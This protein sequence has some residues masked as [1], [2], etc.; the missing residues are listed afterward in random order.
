MNVVKRDGSLE[1]VN[2]EKV[3]KRI[4]L[5]ATEPDLLPEPNAQGVNGSEKAKLSKSDTLEVNATLIAQRTLMRIRDGIKTSELDELAAQLSISLVT[6]HPDYG[7]LASRII[8]SNHQKN[9]NPSFVATMKLLHSQINDKTGRRMEY[10]SD[11]FMTAVERFGPALDAALKHERDFLLDYFGF[12]TQERQKYLLRLIDGRAIERPQH[13]WMRVAVG[14]WGEWALTQIAADAS[15]EAKAVE[16]IVE[17]YDLLSTKQFI[18]ATPTLFNAGSPR[19]QMSSCFLLAMKEDSINGIYETLMNCAKISK[20]AGGIGLHISNI[21]AKGSYING[22]GGTSTGIV[23]M[24]KN[25]NATARYVDQGSKRNGSFAI[26]LEPWH[27]DLEDFLKLKLNTGSEDERARDL[28]YALWIPDLF[29]KRVEQDKTWTLFCPS[30][31]PGL[32]DVWGPAFDELYERY[33]KEGR[34]KRQ[35]E[36]RKLWTKITDCQVETGT[37]YLLYKDA[38]NSKSN[39]QNLGTIKSSNLCVAPETLIYTKQGIIEIKDAVD[40]QVEVWNGTKWSSTVIK[41]TGQNQPL[42]KVNLSNGTTIDC[43]P[44][45]KFIISESY[46]SNKSIKDG[47]RIEAKDLKPGM[48]LQKWNNGLMQGDKANDFKYPYTHGF[49]CG[50]GTYSNGKPVCSLY[51]EKKL[52]ISKLDIKSTSGVLDASERLNTV[53]PTDLEQKFKVPIN[54]SV[55]CRLRWLEGLLDADGSVS[56]NGT[57]ESLQI[58]SINNQFLQDIRIML[59]G[60]GV[61]AKVTKLFEK[62]QTL[63]PDG[64]GNKKMFDCQELWRLLISSSGLYSLIELGLHTHR[65]SIAGNKPQRCAEQYIQVISIEDNGRIDNTYCFNEPENHAGMFNGV[66]TGNCTEIIE[67]SDKDETAVCNLASLGLPSFVEGRKFNFDRLRKVVKVATR[68]LNRVIDINFYP[69]PETRRSNLRHRPIGLGIQGLADV[70]ALLRHPWERDSAAE[71][72]QRI[73]EHIYFAAL[74]ASADL[75][76]LEGPYE[77]FQGSPASKG[78]LQY[79]MW[80]NNGA[81][82]IPLTE[83][84]KTLN[85]SALKARIQTVGIRNSLLV[86]PMPTAS[87]SQILGFNECF[88]PF[89]SNIYA[90][91]TLSGE[92]IVINK[93]LVKDLLK[94]GLWNEELKNKII[95]KN[96]SI[97]GL[98]IPVAIQNLYKTAEE[99]SQKTLIN[100]SAA[101]GAFICQSQSLNLFVKEPTHKKLSSMHFYAWKKGLKT[102]QYYLRTTTQVMAQKFTVDPELQ[103]EAERLEV[104]RQQKEGEVE[105]GCTM[106]SA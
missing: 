79:D 34:G 5:C 103:K 15:Q 75:A 4:T 9:T 70:F 53:L 92:Y 93:Y 7:I 100:M 105:E 27:A 76:E 19:P 46:S 62:R 80:T 82:I 38:A 98:D 88:E 28:F 61:N 73:F 24:L 16:R 97:Q 104:E 56:R 85:W 3:Q 60:L 69:T 72:N 37:P 86:A 99:I 77:T 57:N 94:L 32:A 49:F 6:T 67:Y 50:D 41:Q 64:H 96:G 2:F 10:L 12:K 101:R 13:M 52:L 58:A 1:P 68:N 40:K 54:A 89:T 51:G 26:Y 21:R 63:L 18:H 33:E 25:F 35:V 71:L 22:N 47:I 20:Y 66:L 90:R 43:T 14:M 78:I 65:L 42:I 55:E 95:A 59:M 91:R 17:T 11:G 45:H 36:A 8:I 74:E 81:A 31:A 48:K 30:E 87:T 102:G 44:Y 23:P 39:Q 29:M 83:T 84:D 106:C